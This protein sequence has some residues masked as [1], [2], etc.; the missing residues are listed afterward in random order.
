MALCAIWCPRARP[1]KEYIMTKK[2]LNAMAKADIIQALCDQYTG[3]DLEGFKAQAESLTK[4][5]LVD[6]IY[7]K[8][9]K[10]EEEKTMKANQENQV[11]EAVEEQ[12]AE[13]QVEQKAEQEQKAEPK[14]PQVDPELMAETVASQ[15]DGAEVI[16]VKPNGFGVKLG[17]TRAFAIYRNRTN[18]FRIKTNKVDQAI[19]LLSDYD[20]TI[21]FKMTSDGRDCLLDFNFQEETTVECFLLDLCQTDMSR[22]KRAKKA[23]QAAPE[24]EQAEEQAETK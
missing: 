19:G 20:T 16:A 8:M 17:R 15:I 1:G 4:K 11:V 10:A 13:Q 3:N 9:K 7:R 6:F 24:A 14:R 23:E 21:A 22:K 18:H 2:Q 5:E 12:K